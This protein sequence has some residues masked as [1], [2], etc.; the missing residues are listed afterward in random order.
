MLLDS[1]MGRA[2][3]CCLHLLALRGRNQQD[4]FLFLVGDLSYKIYL[5]DNLMHVVIY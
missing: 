2:A 5:H 4:S 3:V 1:Y